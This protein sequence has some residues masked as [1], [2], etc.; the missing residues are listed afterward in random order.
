MSAKPAPNA[1]TSP[2]SATARASSATPA[3]AR[4]GAAEGRGCPVD[5]SGTLRRDSTRSVLRVI[6]G[7]LALKAFTLR[8]ASPNIT[9][10]SDELGGE[11]AVKTELLEIVASIDELASRG[12]ISR[13]R[14]FAAWYAISFFDL[15]EDDA[16]EAAAADGGND[17][18]IDLVFAD[19]G[20]EEIIAIQAYCPE[21][22]EKKTPKSKW[23][24][25]VSGTVFVS[26]PENL[27]AVGRPDLAES[28]GQIRDAHPEY[29]IVVGLISLGTGSNEISA[30]MKAHRDTKKREKKVSYFFSA[31]EEVIA[32]YQALVSSEDGISEEVLTFSGNHIVDSGEYGKAWIGSVSASELQR[33]HSSHGD[34]LFA[35]NIRL[36]L[37]S[38][39]GGI[40]EQII[41]TAKE[42]PGTFWALDNGITI[43]ADTAEPQSSADQLSRLKI[44]RFSIVNGC[45]TTSS[46]VRAEASSEAKVLT[47]VIAAKAAL[48]NEIVRYNNS[49][50]AIKI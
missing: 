35:G 22:F 7:S 11:F 28:I 8:R 12:R 47:R 14:A 34:K 20:A 10:W 1:A 21:N 41:S 49:Q 45:Q 9:I 42:S 50:N 23:D 38:R 43:V 15:D 2:W 19:E 48:R 6:N 36:F 40:N 31:Q 37:G 18:G 32:K 25:A 29:P 30:S 26:N 27:R 24:A 5:G 39:K 17:Q 46:L 3:G 13:N 16:L 4:R 33:L 44:R